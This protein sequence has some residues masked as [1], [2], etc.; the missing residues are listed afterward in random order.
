MKPIDADRLIEEL[1]YTKI[2]FVEENRDMFFHNSGYNCAVAGAIL[3]AKNQPQ[4]NMWIPCK[5]RL[6]KEHEEVYVTLINYTG[7]RMTS[8]DVFENGKFYHHSKNVIAWMPLPPKY[9]G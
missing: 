3:L 8:V 9:E 6:P 4:V 1:K 2:P 5:E 7:E